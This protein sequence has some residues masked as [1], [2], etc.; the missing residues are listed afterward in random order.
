L[1]IA[2]E[3]TETFPSGGG[4][5]GGTGLAYD[6]DTKADIVGTGGLGSGGSFVFVSPEAVSAVFRASL[7]LAVSRCPLLV[8]P[9]F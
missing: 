5:G 2:D 8:D 6:P 9:T 1:L 4:I 7:F 3:T